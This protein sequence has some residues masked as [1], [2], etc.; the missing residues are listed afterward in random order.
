MVVLIHQRISAGKGWSHALQTVLKNSVTLYT[1]HKVF[2]SSWA[3]GRFFP[4]QNCLCG[5]K[6]PGFVTEPIKKEAF[7]NYYWDLIFFFSPGLP[8]TPSALSI[9]FGCMADGFHFLRSSDWQ[10]CH[11]NQDH[12]NRNWTSGLETRGRWWRYRDTG[13]EQ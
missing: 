8:S 11:N 6:F 7:W 1:F 5:D 10:R 2:C 13:F 9:R 4:N 3:K 12:H